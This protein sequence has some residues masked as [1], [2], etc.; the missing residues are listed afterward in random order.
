L[1]TRLAKF[2]SRLAHLKTRVAIF[3]IR[4]AGL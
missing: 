3:A 4:L 2:A 1:K